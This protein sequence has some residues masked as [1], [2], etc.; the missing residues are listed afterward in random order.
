[1]LKAKKNVRLWFPGI[2]IC[3]H[4][5]LEKRIRIEFEKCERSLGVFFLIYFITVVKAYYL[6]YCVCSDYYYY[7]DSVVVVV[8]CAKQ[9][10]LPSK[11]S[12]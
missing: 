10:A 11:I 1:M 5:K 3:P 7:Y 8:D 6:A 4:P 2:V 12:R 9:N